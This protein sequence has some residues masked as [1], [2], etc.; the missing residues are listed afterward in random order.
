MEDVG[1]LLDYE[2]DLAI[3]SDE[4][5]FECKISTEGHCCEA[6]FFLYLEGTE[7]GGIVDSIEA[8]TANKE[9][10]YSGRT[11]HGM[12]DSKVICPDP[13]EDYLIL[14]GEA[15]AV[16]GTLIARLGLSSLFAASEESSGFT[17]SSFKMDR[18]ISGYKGIKKMLKKHGAKLVIKFI[19]GHVVLSTEAIVD[20]SRD[21]QFDT[22]QIEFNIKKNFKPVNHCICLGKGDLHERMVIHLFADSSGNISE[23]QSLTGLD[24][25]SIVYDYSSAESSEELIK[26]G[27]ELIQD[28][29]NSDEVK[30]DFDSNNEAYDIGDIV[31]A[32]EMVTGLFVAAEITKKI[33]TINKGQTT[34]NYKVGE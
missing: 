30:F 31:G 2:V 4:N 33:V 10:T 15:N 11:W 21:E 17:I 18:Y 27:T 32:T 12:L 14:S 9:I 7:Y 23:T 29:W 16:L 24:E 3:G 28:S 6:G 5:N 8:D 1:V 13:G 19:D 25:V 34:I 20:Y 26:G 22:D